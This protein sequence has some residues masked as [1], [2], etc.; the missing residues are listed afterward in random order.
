VPVA[1]RAQH[2]S[3]G[4]FYEFYW[5]IFH[6]PLG[7]LA[8]FGAGAAG[9]MTQSVLCGLDLLIILSGIWLALSHK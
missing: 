7:N 9:Q 1:T 6:I 8:Q 3:F 4:C 2:L 5:A